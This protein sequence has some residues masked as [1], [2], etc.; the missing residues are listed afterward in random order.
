MKRFLHRWFHWWRTIEEISDRGEFIKGYSIIT[1]TQECT[2]CHQR[3]TFRV[4]G[5][6]GCP[7][8]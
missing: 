7:T 3:R 4:W 5:F 8:Q 1:V 6:G 2:V